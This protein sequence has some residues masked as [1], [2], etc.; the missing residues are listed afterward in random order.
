MKATDADGITTR[1]V[2][3]YFDV[4]PPPLPTPPIDHYAN[5]LT[6]TGAPLVVNGTTAGATTELDEGDIGPFG[7]VGSLRGQVRPP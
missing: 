5:R 3:Q 4:L 6:I 2:N 1:R 7:G